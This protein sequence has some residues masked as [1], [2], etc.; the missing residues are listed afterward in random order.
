M[1]LVSMLF[2]L[3]AVIAMW[4]ELRRWAPE[5]YRTSTAQPNAM[6]VPADDIFL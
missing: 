2:M 5:Y 6:V 3:I 4:A 1:L